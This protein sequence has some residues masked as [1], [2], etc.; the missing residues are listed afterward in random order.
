MRGIDRKAI[1]ANVWPIAFVFDRL[2]TIMA[3]LAQRAQRAEDELVVIA[4]MRRVV[5][6]DRRRRHAVPLEAGSAQRLDAEL[7]M[8]AP[9]PTLEA[10]PGSPGERL[11]G[12]GDTSWHQEPSGRASTARIDLALLRF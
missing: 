12:I 4:L 1:V 11:S 2:Q 5:V 9:S 10:V 3:R 6:G 8:S 7:M